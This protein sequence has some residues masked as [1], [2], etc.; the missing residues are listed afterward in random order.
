MASEERFGY[1]WSRYSKILPQYELQFINW[2]KPLNKNN[3]KNK[4]IF[5][6]GCGMGRNSYFALK[7]GAKSVLAIDNNSQTIN[8]AKS[9]L[10]PFDNVNVEE[11]SI[12]NLDLVTKFDIVMSIG[13]VHHLDDPDL[14]IRNL[15]KILKPGGKLIVWVYSFEGNEWIVN[16]VSPI[17]KKVTSKLP[18]SLLH[19]L[20]YFIC[21]PLFM[22]I[23]CFSMKNMYLK[24][25]ST[26]SFL[27]I[28]SIIFDQLLP[29]IAFYWTE[30][31]CISLFKDNG[32]KTVNVHRP[33]NNQGWTIIAENEY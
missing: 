4:T 32:F 26:F 14:A 11:M 23:K 17:R 20:S 25:I 15:K 9:N 18:I 19:F 33:E 22:Y 7:Y 5:D 12:Y 31:E 6:A 1:E 2:V 10:K 3:F 21:I 28:N 27:H 30:E 13:V 29:R 8:A 24:Q 16:Y